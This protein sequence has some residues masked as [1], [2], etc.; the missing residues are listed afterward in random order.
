[1]ERSRKIEFL[2]GNA[3]LLAV[4]P[5]VYQGGEE[6]EPSSNT[7]NL[8]S[9]AIDYSDAPTSYLGTPII[10]PVT[11]KSKDESI[12]LMLDIALFQIN[13]QKQIVTTALQGVSGTVKEYISDGDYVISI[14]G[15]LT[16][17]TGSYPTEQMQV[18]HQLLLLPEALIV[19]SSL[20]Q[21]LGIYNI[22][23]QSYS[24]EDRAGFE[25]LQDFQL[26]CLSDNPI[27]L[28]IENET[29]N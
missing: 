14:T 10:A 24:F 15:V 17:P 22:V 21:L 26:E 19:E 5:K 4:K 18:L 3:R 28:I 6:L 1:M 29:L 27:E 7:Y 23:V 8:E 12:S 16:N 9:A 25:N 20:L 2:L 13:M 11:I